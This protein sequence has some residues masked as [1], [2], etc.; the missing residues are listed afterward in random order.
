MILTK[1]T[2]IE[3]ASIED[4]SGNEDYDAIRETKIREMIVAQK[5]D[6]Y[7]I[8]ITDVIYER[9][10]LDQPAAQEYIDFV[11]LNAIQYNLN[12]VSTQIL[13]AP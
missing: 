5:T 11:T 7:P 9:Y 2:K 1:I 10:W 13:D 12:L 3:W 6:G 4:I 8:S